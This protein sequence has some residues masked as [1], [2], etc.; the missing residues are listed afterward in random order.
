MT[1]AT[2]TPQRAHTSAPQSSFAS[3]K[4][5]FFGVLRSEFLKFRTLTTNWVMTAII[6]VVMVGLALMLAWSLNTFWDSVQE[7]AQ[8]AAAAGAPEGMDM[9]QDQ[10]VAYA[11]Q[12]GASGID[13]ANMLVGSLAVVFIGSEYAT[14]SMQSTITAVP[15][16]SMAYLGKLIVLSLVTFVMGFVFAAISYFMGH[17]LLRSEITDLAT[18]ESGIVMN[19]LAIALYFMFM[20]WMGLGFGALFRN[21]AAGIMAVVVLFLILPIIMQLMSLGLDWA[22]DV[23]EYLPATLGSGMYAYEVAD[24]E[25][26]QVESGSWLALWAVVPAVLGYL[27]FCFT[28]TK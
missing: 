4:L 13:L 26:N 21:N 1:T 6:L 27:R 8:A 24:G 23:M 15:R 17:L 14:R 9:G 28:D 19:W 10:I 11:R 16:R 2:S 7:Q 18:F 22:K 5:S 12:L 20:A 25:M 3:K